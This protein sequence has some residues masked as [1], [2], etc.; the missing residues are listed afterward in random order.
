[1]QRAVDNN[2]KASMKQPIISS[3]R[4]FA[5]GNGRGTHVVCIPS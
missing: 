5:S 4:I 2:E 1:M 3:E